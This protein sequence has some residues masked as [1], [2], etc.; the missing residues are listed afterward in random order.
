MSISVLKPPKIKEDKTKKVN[1]K[2]MGCSIFDMWGFHIC[3]VCSKKPRL[4]RG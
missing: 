2:L 3:E 4:L 1:K